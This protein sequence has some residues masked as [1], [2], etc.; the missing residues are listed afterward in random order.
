MS[1]TVL[2]AYLENVAKRDYCRESGLYV[3]YDYLDRTISLEQAVQDLTLAGGIGATAL[4]EIYLQAAADQPSKMGELVDK[5]RQSY[6]ARLRDQDLTYGARAAS[7]LVQLGLHRALLGKPRFPTLTELSLAYDGLLTV[8]AAQ[9]NPATYKPS[10]LTPLVQGKIRGDM[11]EAAVLLLA[12]RYALHNDLAQDWLPVKSLLRADIGTSVKGTTKP[13]DGW[14][15][16]IFTPSEINGPQ[17][18]YTIQV[19]AS[20]VAKKKYRDHITVVAVHPD[21]ALNRNSGMTAVEIIKECEFERD[22][23][24]KETRVTRTLNARTEKLLALL[25]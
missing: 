11:S 12:Q 15:I 25:D 23:S 14:D 19:K 22:N 3:T 2:D 13:A 10:Q 1:E 6:E 21:L 16:E 5:A 20:R 4:G 24:D 17:I 7:R 8:A 18:S 9:V